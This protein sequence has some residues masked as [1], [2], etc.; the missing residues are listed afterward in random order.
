MPTVWHRCT[1][2]ILSSWCFNVLDSLRAAT[3]YGPYFTGPA[4]RGHLVAKCIRE[5]LNRYST[6]ISGAV[7]KVRFN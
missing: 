4:L 2:T 1:V 6:L 7:F 5:P 3:S